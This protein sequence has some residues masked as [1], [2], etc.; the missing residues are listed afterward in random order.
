MKG[1]IQKEHAG[2]SA[3]R[4]KPAGARGTDGQPK[5]SRKG[6]GRPGSGGERRT[7][8]RADGQVE[9]QS[10]DCRVAPAPLAG[11]AVGPGFHRAAADP[12]L[13]RVG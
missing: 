8:L 13:F 9:Q 5:Q 3:P 6:L 2:S 12:A 1:A 10:R 4:V 11:H 7:A